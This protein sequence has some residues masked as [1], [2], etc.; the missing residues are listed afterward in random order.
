MSQFKLFSFI[1]FIIGISINIACIPTKVGVG[2]KA[3][4]HQKQLENA[5]MISCQPQPNETRYSEATGGGRGILSSAAAGKAEKLSFSSAD[6]IYMPQD[7]RPAIN[8]VKTL[9]AAAEDTLILPDFEGDDFFFAHEQGENIF[10]DKQGQ[11]ISDIDQQGQ[12][13]VLDSIFD[14]LP[15][16]IRYR[17]LHHA[18]GGVISK[19]VAGEGELATANFSFNSDT[20]QSITS[21][22]SQTNPAAGNIQPLPPVGNPQPSPATPIPA[23]GLLFLIGLLTLIGIRRIMP[24]KQ[25][26]PMLKK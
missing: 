9:L 15:G 25:M 14:P 24:F 26:F 22:G 1:V 17:A 13:L 23:T 16:D 12:D 2:R 11:A 19:R 18:Y 6:Q 4:G 10:S 7:V 20:H 21:G 5:S 3:F 8:E